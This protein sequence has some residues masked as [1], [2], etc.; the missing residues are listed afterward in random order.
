MKNGMIQLKKVMKI[1][2]W[3]LF[4]L[5]FTTVLLLGILL[6]F[7]AGEDIWIPGGHHFFFGLDLSYRLIAGIVV[8]ILIGLG[9]YGFYWVVKMIVHTVQHH[10][11]FLN[12]KPKIAMGFLVMFAIAGV[13]YYNPF[14]LYDQNLGITPKFGPYIGYYGEN[15]MIVAWDGPYSEPLTVE[16]GLSPELS[17]LNTEIESSLQQWAITPNN[18]NYHHAAILPDLLSDT[19]YY[20]RIPEL[21][22]TIY[23]F[24]TAP[25]PESGKPVT[26]TIVGDTQ[27]GYPGIK[28]IVQLMQND[29]QPADF[30]CIAGD[31]VNRDDKLSEWATLFAQNSYGGIASSIPWMNAPGNHEFSCEESDCGFREQ[32]KLFFD[33]NYP[34]NYTQLPN[35]PDYGLYYSYNV[36]NVHMVSLDVFDNETYTRAQEKNSGSFLTTSQLE[37]LEEDLAR[38]ANMWKFVYFHVPMYSLSDYPSNEDLCEQLEPI[39]DEYQVDAVFTGHN[40]N[41]EAFLVN[42]SAAD[43]GIYHFMVGGGGA[44]IDNMMDVEDY[45]SRSWPTMAIN[46][47]APDYDGRY[48]AI[49]GSEYQLY[50]ELAFNYMK[51]HV[52]GDTVTFSAIRA[53][54]GSIIVQYSATR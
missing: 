11:F 44:G 49:Y 34:S 14:W 46:I 45:G 38:N 33:Y 24:H 3:I 31:L 18:N 2:G 35:T 53:N 6:P 23:S 16:Y 7:V 39:F 50:G 8:L 1:G 25:V 5:F 51:V 54:D 41:F 48:D 47:S 29:P 15:Q 43:G 26:F 9:G 42:G 32:Y 10:Q 17:S 36:S 4:A 27:G 30:T 37:W 20:Y 12:W 40:H 52:E 28:K 13:L 19:S 21:G 22:S